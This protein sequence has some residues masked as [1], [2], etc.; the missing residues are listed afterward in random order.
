[1]KAV[2]APALQAHVAARPSKIVLENLSKVFTDRQGRPVEAL[3]N[4]NLAV[5]EGEF[6]CVVGPSGCGK[7]SLLRIVAGLEREFEGRA[8][9]W[10]SDPERPMT[11]V[12][13][14]EHAVFPWMTVEENVA[15][16]LTIRKHPAAFIRDRVGDLL[17]R[18]GLERFAS[19]Y[20]FQLS[21]GMKQRVSV[22]RAFAADPEVLLMDEPFAA[23]DE[24]TKIVLH[25]ELLKLW[26]EEAKTV[27]FITHSIDEA[28]VLA[29]RIVIMS[30][31]PGAIQEE[32]LVPFSRPRDVMRVKADPRYGVL[33]ARIWN[34]LRQVRE[35]PQLQ[36]P[37]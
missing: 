4:I 23:L 19:A 27:I 6:V 25:G 37:S 24:Q 26:E 34:A 11:S 10:Q 9:L 16:G 3:R 15:Y 22:L 28:L 1:M 7:S 32:I 21:G 18:A 14:Q 5:G 2:S 29:D 30:A 31:R 20:P 33:V 36:D 35:F 13:F 12:V 8:S 17:R